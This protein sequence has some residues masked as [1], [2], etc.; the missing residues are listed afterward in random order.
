MATLSNVFW[1]N[2]AASMMHGG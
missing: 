1:G 2:I